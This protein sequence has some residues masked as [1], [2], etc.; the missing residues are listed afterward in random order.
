MI[1]QSVTHHKRVLFVDDD[2]NVLQ[3]LRRMLHPMKQRWDMKFAGS[4]AE[5]LERLARSRFDVIITEMRMTQI[6]GAQ[7]LAP[8]RARHP[9]VARIILSG[10]SD[11]ELVLQAAGL[12]H[13]YLAKPCDA[14]ILKAVIARSCALREMLASDRLR[15]IFTRIQGIP[16][17]PVVYTKM[18]AEIQSAN[19]SIQKV[20]Q[21]ISEDPGMIAKVL[22]LV[23]SAFFGL[24]RQVTSPTQAVN[25]LGLDTIKALSLVI[26]IFACY[27]GEG[28]QN[29]GLDTIWEHTMRT[30]AYARLIAQSESKDEKLIG[31]A[32]MGGL[33]HDI[34]RLILAANL[35]EQYRQAVE[36]AE[37]QRI[38]LWQA[39]REVIG[40]SHDSAG[41]FLLGLWGL[42]DS[43]L[44]AVVFHHRPLDC[45]NPHFAPLTAVHVADELDCLQRTNRAAGVPHADPK[46]LASHVSATTQ[47]YLKALNLQNRLPEWLGLCFEL[48]ARLPEETEANV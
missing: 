42:P 43:L 8:V 1:E 20:G 33:L 48:Q 46:A 13:Q 27:E 21:I 28:A 4:G 41:G 18:M 7:L 9:E 15:R 10:H 3:G 22:Q 35:P 24:P 14:E 31:D 34:G 5:A 38:P 44:E 45:P 23:N 32:F 26:H 12:A 37:K 29:F 16:S 11:R 47:K 6:N 25:L 2:A 17:I 40:A 19:A 39:E 30:G 36:M